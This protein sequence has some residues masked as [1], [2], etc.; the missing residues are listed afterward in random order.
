MRFRTM[1]AVAVLG[2]AVSLFS[3]VSAKR[4]LKA[5]DLYRTKQVR[6]P[7]VSPDGKLVAY[8]VTSIDREADK[9]VT[10]VW[11]VNWEGTQDIQLTYGEKSA[12]TPRW[13]PDGKYLAFLSARAAE[14][15][16]QIWVLD[17]RGGEARQ[18]TDVKGEIDS[19]EWSPDR[20]RIVLAMADSEEDVAAPGAKPKAPK[21]I[22]LDRYHFKRDIEGYLTTKSLRR[23]Y[24]FDM[25]SKKLEALTAR[26][27]LMRAVWSGLRTGRTLRSSATMRRNRTKAGRATFLSLSPGQGSQRAS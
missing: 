14:D 9:R 19:Y 27:T 12:G 3:Q 17:R 10:A 11:M 20:K 23:L 16:S 7:Q 13:S 8:T 22:V 21:P 5:E 18:L 2:C 15:K 24:L 25:E 1:A 4:P 26:R 6:D